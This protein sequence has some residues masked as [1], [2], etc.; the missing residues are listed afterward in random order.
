MISRSAGSMCSTAFN[1][2]LTVFLYVDLPCLPARGDHRVLV[3]AGGEG[4]KV[5]MDKGAGDGGATGYH[6]RMRLLVSVPLS[7]RQ[8]SHRTSERLGIAST[9]T[10]GG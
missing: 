2:S 1:G 6:R 3:P 4:P 9:S 7:P 10:R 5:N 8:P